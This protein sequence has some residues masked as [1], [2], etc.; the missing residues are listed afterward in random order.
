LR[1]GREAWI[2]GVLL[3]LF[4]L[5]S[6]YYTRRGI[7][8]EEKGRP[9]T[10]SAGPNGLAA[11]YRVLQRQGF[12]AKQYR[13]DF[14]RI[15]VNAGLVVIAEPIE[16]QITEVESEA[17]WK[18]VD[19]GGALLFIVTDNA[20]A[21]SASEMLL[22]DHLRIDLKRSVPQDIAVDPKSSKYLRDVH[23]IHVDGTLRLAA[24]GSAKTL[25]EDGQGGYA[26]SWTRGKGTAIAAMSSLG[27]DNAHIQRADNA[28]FF[29]NIAEAH[30]HSGQRTIFFDEYH[31][32]FGE[33]LEGRSL[34]DALGASVRAVF[35][36]LAA[37]FFI[38]VYNLNRRFGSAK[39]LIIPS[40]RPSTEY[41]SSMASLYRK[42]GAG[43]IAIETIYKGF[44]RDLASK[45]DT[46]L[47]A[48]T[49][50]MV[51]AGH[52]RYGWETSQFREMINR[53]EAIVRGERITES[54]MLRL[55]TQIEDYRRKADLARLP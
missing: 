54:E 9:T 5:F 16:R 21:V 52:R 38:L 47:D 19:A 2:L 22:S 33:V 51:E 50:L 53:C 40:Y 17:L 12:T 43:D 46:Q 49:D 3:L 27:F 30:S 28:L 10:N 29:V 15:P 11:L 48:G 8:E 20:F 7:Q 18:W 13:Q 39:R 37:A 32:G 6:A 45:L 4:V 14:T 25:L 34:W 41:I 24:R 55:A 42:A 23:S 26:V 44:L 1:I 31:Q 35:W 36:Y